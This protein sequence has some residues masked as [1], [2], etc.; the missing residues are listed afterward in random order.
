MREAD[1]SEASSD[2][3]SLSAVKVLTCAVQKSEN[4]SGRAGE[5]ENDDKKFVSV[6][7]KVEPTEHNSSV[8]MVAADERTASVSCVK[9]ESDNTPCDT[10]T[11]RLKVIDEE[12]DSERSAE[13]AEKQPPASEAVVDGNMKRSNAVGL[14]GET[15]PQLDSCVS[16]SANV[17]DVCQ[18]VVE[19]ER[20]CSKTNA[21][22]LIESDSC[23]AAANSLSVNVGNVGNVQH[24]DDNT[25][26]NN[27]SETTCQPVSCD[28]VTKSADL[29]CEDQEQSVESKAD[30]SIAA[31]T[32][33]KCSSPQKLKKLTSKPAT[34]PPDSPGL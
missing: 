3:V 30:V 7:V 13:S 24:T 11:V 16:V 8:Q 20:G 27:V 5:T 17:S 23:E 14:A 4:F 9:V 28:N 21:D 25:A 31:Q 22:N 15:T 2:A 6:S 1:V 18:P 10:E 19:R 34:T 26:S 12:P 29:Q 33:S 32:K